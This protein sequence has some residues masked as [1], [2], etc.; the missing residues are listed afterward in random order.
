MA[1]FLF[2][3]KGHDHRVYRILKASNFR[4]I[5]VTEP[6]GAVLGEPGSLRAAR[7]ARWARTI[8]H[9]GRVDDIFKRGGPV[10]LHFVI[11]IGSEIDLPAGHSPGALVGA[12]P[13]WEVALFNS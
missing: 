7:R 13:R 1:S 11:A 4:P 3:L 8:Q 2:Q 9:P 5:S 12:P 10:V 6:T